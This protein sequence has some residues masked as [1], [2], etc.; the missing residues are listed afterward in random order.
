MNFFG[1]W[2]VHMLLRPSLTYFVAVIISSVIWPNSIFLLATFA[3]S[4]KYFGLCVSSQ[5]FFIFIFFHQQILVPFLYHQDHCSSWT[6]GCGQRPLNHQLLAYYPKLCGQKTNHS[7]Y[8]RRT[9]NEL[10]MQRTVEKH[11][12]NNGQHLLLEDMQQDC[13]HPFELI[14]ERNSRCIKKTTPTDNR[15]SITKQITKPQ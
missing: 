5:I 6:K 8:Q 9:T 11:N 10:I 4:P 12:N 2:Q 13:I 3:L 1:F 14:D 15:T 7:N